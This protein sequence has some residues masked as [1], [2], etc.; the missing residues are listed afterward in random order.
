MVKTSP[1]ISASTEEQVMAAKS[2]SRATEK[3]IV[4]GAAVVALL[5]KSIIAWHSFG[6]NDV[7]TFYLFSKVL[8][9]HGLGW[10]YQNVILFNHPPLTAYFLELLQYLQRIPILQA[11][12]ISFPFLLRLP[13]VLAD[14]IAVLVLLRFKSQDARLY[15]PTWAL[16]LFALNPLS[17]M[18]SGFHGNTDSIM[19]M[20]LVVS[21]YFASR[22]RPLL[23]GLF[24]ALST[25]VKIAPLLFA[26]VLFFYWWQRG[27]A[28][29]FSIP[30]TLTSLLLWSE[31]LLFFPR[32]FLHNVVSYSSYWGI[33][34]FSYLLRMTGRQEFSRVS[35]FGLAHSQDA[36]MQICKIIIVAIVLTV[37][38]RRRKT[39]SAGLRDS[40]AY[41]WLAFFIFAPGVCVQYLIW[42]APFFLF[43]SPGFYACVMISSSIFAF[44][45]YNA[46]ADRFPWYHAISTTRLVDIWAA[47]SLLPWGVF[48]AGGIYFCRPMLRRLFSL[49][50]PSTP[51]E[52]AQVEA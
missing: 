23:C 10:T 40:L 16:V 6:T 38:W 14:F 32:L 50:I 20:F 45:F 43:L 33:W 8:I 7:V 11:N 34:G 44:A 1:D 29:R 22:E 13:G 46:I 36:V 27:S 41:A 12:G 15:L 52:V 51:H 2:S 37:A 25:Q 42:C 21:V 3:R 26:P 31:P 5:V 24:L 49:R 17:I 48:I 18:V 4:L 28:L 19:V 47:W 9:E 35:F 30:F 39:D